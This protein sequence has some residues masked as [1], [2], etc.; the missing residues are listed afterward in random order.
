MKTR[1]M[2]L[3]TSTAAR[4]SACLYQR[5]ALAGGARR[6][7]QWPD[8]PFLALNEDQCFALVEGMITERDEIGPGIQQVT[9]KRLQ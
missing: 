8:Q 5:D 7:V 9:A 3:A 4:R 1:P 6:E 2:T